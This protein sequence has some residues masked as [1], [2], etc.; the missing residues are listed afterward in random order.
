M[1]TTTDKF[2]TE[3]QPAAVLKHGILRRY[4]P[5]YARKTGSTSRDRKVAYLDCFAGPGRYDDGSPG[6][7]AHAVETAKAI[8]DAGAPDGQYRVEGYLI[9][10]DPTA[11]RALCTY[12]DEE[13]L[14]WRP[15]RGD[16]AVLLDGVLAEIDSG[17]SLFAFIDP[18]GLGIRF[19]QIT[20]I[21]ARA[22]RNVGRWRTGSATE[23][24]LNF[25]FPGLRRTAGH[26][27]GAGTDPGYL[28][29]RDTILRKLDATLGGD[30][31]REIWRSG[32]ADR[33]TQ[34]FEQYRQRL[35]TSSGTW[36]WWSVPVSDRWQGRPDYMLL[37]LTQHRDGI[38]HFN[39]ALSNSLGEYRE[40]CAAGAAQLDFDSLWQGDDQWVTQIAANIER[41]LAQG[42]F[43]IGDQMN[44]VYGE[45]LGFAREKHVRAAVKQLHKVGKTPT[46]CVGKAIPSLVVN[47]P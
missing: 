15:Y 14:D 2:F 17:L 12:L 11:Y 23:V 30:W 26:L 34:I 7:P 42:A 9:E 5:V 13:G 31:W 3:I 19:D 41:R 8:T 47:P 25:S 10:K 36:A 29:S 38:W 4:F 20:S 39:E 28:K 18:F 37:L 33:E 1:A 43:R 44:A 6:S 27:T 32:D 40:A 46:D 22:G 45:T 35:S 24:L 21:L 16:A